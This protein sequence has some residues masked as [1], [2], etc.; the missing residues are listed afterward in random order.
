[1]KLHTWT[2][3]FWARV[4]RDDVAEVDISIGSRQL[5]DVFFVRRSTH[6]SFPGFFY[7]F[8]KDDGGTNAIQKLITD[9]ISEIESRAK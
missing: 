6:P 3:A 7:R 9:A 5:Q 2:N 4:I 1:M 8:F